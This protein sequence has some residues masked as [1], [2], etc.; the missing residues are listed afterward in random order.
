MSPLSPGKPLG[1]SYY[2][3]AMQLMK[4]NHLYTH[5]SLVP[6]I[7]FCNAEY[8]WGENIVEKFEKVI[9]VRANLSVAI[10]ET[11]AQNFWGH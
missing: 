10:S 7:V 2:M 4:S 11:F 5:I 1:C 8:P 3:D 9:Q 6:L